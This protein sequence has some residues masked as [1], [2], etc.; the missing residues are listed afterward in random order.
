MYKQSVFLYVYE[1]LKKDFLRIKKEEALDSAV[2]MMLL[3]GRDEVLVFSDAIK[4]LGI[5]TKTDIKRLK[6]GGADFSLPVHNFMSTRLISIDKNSTV[7]SARDLMIKE[8]I[9]RLIVLENGEIIGIVTAYD[10]LNTFYLKVEEIELQLRTILE[11]L[12]EAVC[13]VDTNGI[14]TFW[15]KNSEKLYGVP[16]ENI[17]GKQI[18]DFF[19]N[20]L[21]LKALEDKKAFENHTHRPKQG[22]YVVISAIPLLYGDK[23]IG[24]VSTD[25][26]ITEITNLSM[27][28]EQHKYR[29]K[30]LEEQMKNIIEDKYSFGSIIGKSK[31]IANAIIMAKKVSKTDASVLITGESGTGKEVF[32]RA[33]HHQ[34]SKTGNFVPINCSAIPSNLLE[35]ELFG[36]SEGAFTGALKK[37]KIGKFELA[38]NGTLFLDEIGDMPL[39]MQ[40]K[41]LRVLQD[42]VI[43]RVGATK[44]INV[45][46]RIIAATNK[47]LRKLM[48]QGAFRE[49]LYYRLNVVNIV[50]PPLRERKEDIPELIKSFLDEFA[51]KNEISSI[52]ISPEVMMILTD[53]KWA[54]NIRELR[55]II[56]RLVILSPDGKIEKDKLTD[57]ILSYRQNGSNIDETD[58]DSFNLQKKVYELEKRTIK[59]VMELTEGN[60]YRAAELLNLKRATLYYKLKQY[61][62]D[63]ECQKTDTKSKN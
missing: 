24:A 21:L 43:M 3:S 4:L 54:G 36:Y 31:S 58:E 44:S 56:E 11:N 45:N 42:G 25:R 55:N 37:G 6:L 63:E 59:K 8:G 22:S 16:C 2:N 27:Q 23:L 32:A 1:I 38:N 14:V 52:E 62:I 10:L 30:F 17:I 60:K 18:R 20:A 61:G 50:L 53:Y 26:D 57:E 49:D 5:I 41:L 12:H 33:I 19:P 51:I 40:A 48:S 15:N 9:G 35:S 34:S 47:D 7:R 13:V 46:V 28:L 29:V 39:E